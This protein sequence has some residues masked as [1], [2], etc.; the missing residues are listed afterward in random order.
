MLFCLTLHWL[1]LKTWFFTDDFAWLGLKLEVQSPFDLVHVL[2]S[3]QAQGTVR[4]LSER[5]FFLVF[6]WI[7]GLESPPFRIWVFLTQFA[8]IVLLI[9]ITRRLTGSAVAG[10]LAAILW[11]VTAGLAYAL[12]Q[13]A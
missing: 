8:S 3:P 6:S 12:V 10:F 2:F 13:S 7:F 1:A 5:L 9:K 11:C 4:T